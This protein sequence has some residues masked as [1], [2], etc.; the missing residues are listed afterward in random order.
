[1]PELQSYVITNSKLN[2]VN[3]KALLTGNMIPVNVSG[4]VLDYLKA[5]GCYNSQAD[6]FNGSVYF[7]NN[8]SIGDA[9]ERVDEI[10]T[11]ADLPRIKKDFEKT[12]QGFLMAK[13]DAGKFRDYRNQGHIANISAIDSLILDQ[14]LPKEL[15]IDG[16]IRDMTLQESV[17]LMSSDPQFKKVMG[18]YWIWNDEKIV[19][20]VSQPTFGYVK[21]GD[22]KLVAAVGDEILTPKKSASV[23]S[24]WGWDEARSVA[25]AYRLPHWSDDDVARK[26]SVEKS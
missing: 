11:V 10:M 12:K 6:V 2:A 19:Q 9:F 22:G 20:I 17:D 23:W 5:A 4:G 16:I 7:G 3:G 13:G 26:I 1:M 24:C 14:K 21:S 8:F 15:K 18:N 25:C